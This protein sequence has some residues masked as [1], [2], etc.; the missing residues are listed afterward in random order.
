MISGIVYFE[1]I[2]ENIKDITGIENMMP[3]YDKVRRFIFNA[4]RDIAAGGLIVR[5]KR[6]Y[7]IGDGFYDGRNII[8]P[9]DFI[10]EYSYGDLSAGVLNGNILTLYCKGADNIELTYLGFLLDDNGNPFTTRNH[11][12]AVV[13][14]ARHRLYSA[15]VFM[16]EGSHGLY[17]EW[18][19]EY[20]DEVMAARG[21]DAFPTEEEWEAIG[22]TLNG[23]AFE[24]YTNCGM[25]CVGSPCEDAT[26][27]DGGVNPP[28]EGDD[29]TPLVCNVV[30]LFNN[31]LVDPY[32]YTPLP[33][34]DPS[35]GGSSTVTG[36][37]TSFTQVAFGQATVT[38]FLGAI[39]SITGTASG[40]S[41][42]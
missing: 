39:V 6:K 33:T 23:G 22:R 42:V 21:N 24:A 1:E 28:G 3:L 16:K 14:Y 31:S 41:S 12:E 2:V 4:E 11:L 37:L 35:V 9:Y 38:G 8:M 30:A 34:Y 7:S 29:G 13:L 15:K 17:R 40:S 26:A 5:K 25:K 20:F 18:K 32:T 19:Q 27:E 36:T 10:G